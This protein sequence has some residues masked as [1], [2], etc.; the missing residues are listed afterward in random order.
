MLAQDKIKRVFCIGRNYRLHAQELNNVVPE[1]PVVFLKPRESIL[2]EGS[3]I[4]HPAPGRDLQFETEWVVRIGKEGF[5]KEGEA[6]ADWIEGMTLGLDLTLRDLQESLKKKGLPWE[7]AKAFDGSA[8][9]GAF[10]PYVPEKL[11]FTCHVNDRLRQTG[12]TEL[13]IFS[14]D[15]CLAEISRYWRLLPGD[16]V[17]TGTPEGVGSLASGDRVTIASASIGAFSWFVR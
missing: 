14:I 3:E 12:N 7:K 15:S 4:I 9:L 16:I 8:P 11:T 10:V 13:M 5:Y 1:R 2:F 6:A 17:Y